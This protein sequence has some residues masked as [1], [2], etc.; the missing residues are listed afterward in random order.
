MRSN[1][2]LEYMDYVHRKGEVNILEGLELH[3][4]VLS[5]VEQDLMRDT[6]EKW[7]Q[8]GFSVT[9]SSDISQLSLE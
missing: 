3:Q 6:I 7:V 2:N 1:R 9:A 5:A 4:Q 8:Q